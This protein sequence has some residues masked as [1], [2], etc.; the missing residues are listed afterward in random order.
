MDPENETNKGVPKGHSRSK[1]NLIKLNQNFSKHKLREFQIQ[2][3]E[4]EKKILI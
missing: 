4:S 2:L 3:E 1:Q